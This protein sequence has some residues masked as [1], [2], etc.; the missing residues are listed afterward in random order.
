LT[1]LTNSDNTAGPDSTINLGTAGA[2]AA[3][4]HIGNPGANVSITEA[5]WAVTANGD[6]NFAGLT[7]IG[8]VDGGSLDITNNGTIGGT[9]TLGGKMTITAGGFDITGNSDMRGDVDMHNNQITN[10]GNAGTDFTG[11]GGLNLAGTLTANGGIDMSGNDITSAGDITA[12]GTTRSNG[13]FNVGGDDGI[14]ATLDTVKNDGTTPCTITV[15][16]GII[17]ASTCQ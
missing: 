13:G 9:L 8:N 6:A 15:K 14:N 12:T 5:D 2:D 17:T 7:V 16:G 11:A 1:G 4:I 10:I 3:Q